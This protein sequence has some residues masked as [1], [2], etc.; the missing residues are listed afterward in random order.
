MS[1]TDKAKN[2]VEEVGGKAKE[3]VGKHANDQ[4]L[5]TEGKTDQAKGNLK[6]AGEKIKDAF[7]SSNTTRDGS[8]TS[9]REARAAFPC[10]AH[11]GTWSVRIRAP[12]YTS[13]SLGNTKCAQLRRECAGRS[14]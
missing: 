6:Q 10:G 11:L 12:M 8:L 14:R 5:E 4:D 1:A 3:E 13:N 9:A 2:K 7:L